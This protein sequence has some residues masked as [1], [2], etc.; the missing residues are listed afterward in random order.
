[1]IDIAV[2]QGS[3]RPG[4]N[5]AAV[6]RWVHTL[7]SQRTD[8]HFD[9]VDL[10]DFELPLLDEY[11][12]PSL[13]QYAHEH[14]RAWAGTIDRYDGFVFV[15]PEYNHSTSAALKN[16]IDFLYAEWTNK[17]AGFVGYGLQGGLRAVEHLRQVM[18]ELQIADVQAQVALHIHSDF[19]NYTQ[20]SPQ[21]HHEEILH[22]MLGQLVPWSTAMHSARA[23]GADRADA[24]VQRWA[25]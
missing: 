10:R 1:M 22:T 9:L 15:T 19:E 2:I 8:A 21:P 6:A 23:T 12:P 24:H 20:F 17:A 13:G 25:S 3:T 14:T 4:C 5:G 7:A 18:A 11:V 16:A